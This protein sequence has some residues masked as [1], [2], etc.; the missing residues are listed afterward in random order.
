MS[1]HLSTAPQLTRSA[2]RKSDYQ[3]R[4]EARA[5]I[6]KK[7]KARM[8]LIIHITM[9]V[10]LIA[11]LWVIWFALRGRFAWPA[12]PTI[13]WGIALFFHGLSYRNDHGA[14][15]HKRRQ[16]TQKA[17]EAE[18]ERLKSARNNN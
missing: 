14:G 9:Y 17:I 18:F 7:Q 11:S 12:L 15:A 4:Q 1:D 5:N 10:V 3:L 16:Q 8:E 13:I 2:E 6:E